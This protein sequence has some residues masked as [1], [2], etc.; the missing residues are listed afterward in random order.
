MNFLQNVNISSPSFWL[1]FLG[2]ILFAWIISK[3]IIYIPKT[4]KKSQKKYSAVRDN[5]SISTE[6]RLRNDIYRFSQKQHLAASLFSLDEIVIEPKVLTPL[7]QT[8]K[9]LE[10]AP[11]DSVSLTIPYIPDWPEFASIFKASTLTLIEGLQGGS[12]I[13]LAG[14]PGSGKTV[15]LAWLACCIAGNKKGLGKLSGLLPI[16]VH[17]SDI[18]HLFDQINTGVNG[19]S[20]GDIENSEVGE[21][22]RINNVHNPDEV[23]NLLIQA[24]SVYVSP[25][26]LPK[27]PRLIESALENQQGIIIIDRADELPPKQARM[28]VDYIEILQNKYPKLQIIIAMSYDDL[29]GLPTLGFTLLG[30]AAWTDDDRLKL[31]ERWSQQWSKWISPTIKTQHNKVNLS[32]LKSWLC[33]NNEIMKPLEFTLKIWAAF[34][35]DILGSDGPNA[36]DSYIRRAISDAPDALP[37]LESLAL[38]LLL[39]FELMTNPSETNRTVSQITPDIQS[40]D[41]SEVNEQTDSTKLPS[42]LPVQVKELH[43]IDTLIKN[44]L[45]R[46]Y[47]GSRIGFSHP[48]FLGY[49]AGNALVANNLSHNL[50][51]QPSWIGR[52]LSLYYLA[53]NGDVTDLIQPFLQDDDNLHTNHLLISRWLQVAPKNRA[54]RTIIL[55][56]LTSIVQKEK[57]TISLAAKIIAAMSFS[58]DVGVSLYFRQLLKN[59]HPT[60]K[61]LGAL[62]CGILAEKKAIEDLNLLLQE[63]S[64]ISVRSACLA[65]AAIG[66]KQSLE[67]LASSLLNGTEELRRYAAEALANNPQE[68]HPALR[69]GSSMD[70]LLV[71]RSV[72]FGL[73]RINQPWATKIVENLQLEDNEWVVRNAAIQA[74]DEVRRKADYA[75]TPVPD[76]TE[77]RWLIEFADRTGTTIAPG[78][79]A[80]QLVGKALANGTPDEKL[81]AMDYFRTRCDP[82]T[83][84]LIFSIYSSSTGE[85]RDTAYY[86]LWLMTIAG[87]KLPISFE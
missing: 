65:L 5:F 15:A 18:P 81:W 45:L 51:K 43:G 32:Y 53:R 55:R 16:Y 80:E 28:I 23:I 26:T 36:I 11:T 63:P 78:K 19:T 56:T 20:D 6:V 74:F 7:I 72:V 87:I 1:G 60:L 24:I 38:R 84:E 34:S 57:E 33:V 27:L 71:R 31:L 67:I 25:L 44:G 10:L 40:S 39:G 64:P 70:D 58:G 14:H 77:T 66:D 73:I 79:P 75:P 85:L 69:E 76:L 13:I 46:S 4:I 48:V 30:M 9:S 29:A 22:Q 17:A 86:L 83:K 12:N 21:K 2:G 42:N 54:W 47:P 50:Q 37:G 52:N 68:G 8:P 82:S 35:G 59:D 49:L 62:G 41:T 3:L 61:Q